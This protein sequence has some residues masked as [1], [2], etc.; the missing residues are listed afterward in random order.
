M[1]LVDPEY[2]KTFD[3]SLDRDIGLL[4]GVLSH[5]QFLLGDGAFF[6]QDPRTHQLRDCQPLVLDGS[7][8]ASC[9]R[10]WLIGVRAQW[11][12]CHTPSRMDNEAV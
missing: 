3:G 4:F 5:F 10:V 9:G 12:R 8:M 6:G 11:G 2:A 1:I 7:C